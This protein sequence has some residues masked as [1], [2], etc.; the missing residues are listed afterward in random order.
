M[1]LFRRNTNYVGD[2]FLYNRMYTFL[3][4]ELKE[5][6]LKELYLDREYSIATNSITLRYYNYDF[7]KFWNIKII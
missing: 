7:I 1:V 4:N 6:Q 3:I 5:N 2:E